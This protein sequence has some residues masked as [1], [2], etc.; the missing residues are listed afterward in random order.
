MLQRGEGHGE[1]RVL[2]ATAGR[3]VVAT[4]LPAPGFWQ[5]EDVDHLNG[6]FEWGIAM[7]LANRNNLA[8]TVIDV[9][10][11]DIVTGNLHGVDLAISQVS[12]TD[13]R[14]QYV[15]FSDGYFTSQPAVVARMGK[16]LTDL[17]TARSW[18]WAVRAS[19]TEADFV[20]NVIRPDQ[21]ARITS[22]EQTAIDAVRAGQVDAALMDLPTALVLTNGASDV[23]AISRFDQTEDYGVVLPNQSG[24]VEIVNKNLASMRTDGTLDDLYSKWLAPAFS[25]DPNSLPVVL[26]PLNPESEWICCT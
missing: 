19:T 3:L 12:I 14:R 16:T 18:T 17:A 7:E 25:V 10:F 15:D 20:D 22:S 26:T 24:N 23:V 9:P 1:E 21:P 5:G 6:G 13:Q 8:L 2:P 4:T 11:G